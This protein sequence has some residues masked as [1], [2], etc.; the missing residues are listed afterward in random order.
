MNKLLRWFG[1]ALALGMIVALLFR[2]RRYIFNVLDF[3]AVGNGHVD[4]APAIR[5]AIHAAERH[6]GGTI[7]FPKGDYWLRG[8][9]G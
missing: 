8:T 2:K 9:A 3:G 5:A 7:Y 6:G 4:D 1:I